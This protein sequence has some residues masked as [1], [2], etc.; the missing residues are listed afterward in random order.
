M[1]AALRLTAGG[2]ST[3]THAKPG[4]ATTAVGMQRNLKSGS[5]QFPQPCG[6][7]GTGRVGL[8]DHVRRAILIW[9]TCCCRTWRMWR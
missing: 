5:G 2:S 8:C 9:L 6:V 4:Y 7:S 3:A 1:L